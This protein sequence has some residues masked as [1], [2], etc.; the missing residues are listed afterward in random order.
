VEQFTQRIYGL[1]SSEFFS[2]HEDLL[3]SLR[4]LLVPAQLQALGRD[5]IRYA[6]PQLQHWQEQ[7]QVGAL[8]GWS[9]VV[10][11]TSF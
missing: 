7:G 10:R 2:R 9:F 11:H 1:P 4:G 8:A 5:L 6:L 3:A